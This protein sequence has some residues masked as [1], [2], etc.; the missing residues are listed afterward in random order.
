MGDQGIR[1]LSPFHD[2]RFTVQRW[3]L[4]RRL[5]LMGVIR[6]VLTLV[7]MPLLF[8][9]CVSNSSEYRFSISLA[10]VRISGLLALCSRVVSPEAYFATMSSCEEPHCIRSL[11]IQ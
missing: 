2:E 10:T 1:N 8:M 4:H 11:Q 7:S 6:L 9:S 5:A 3:G